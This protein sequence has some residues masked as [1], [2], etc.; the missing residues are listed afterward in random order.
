MTL[1]RSRHA[2]TL[3]ELLVVIAIIG[4]LIGLLLPA[5]QK[6]RE[7][8]MRMRCQNN[9][10]QIGLALQGYHDAYT[11][12]PA[13]SDNVTGAY[14]FGNWRYRILPYMEQENMYKTPIGGN[15]VWRTSNATNGYTGQSQLPDYLV[16]WGKF[17]VPIYRCPS[18]R[19]SAT[20][21]SV[22]CHATLGCIDSQAID[23]VGVMG[24]NPDP[25]GRDGAAVRF[26]GNPSVG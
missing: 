16:A 23:Y 25:A 20:V 19:L 13:G 22:Q 24:A 26:L 1:R 5:V 4:V 2:F 12:F 6:V 11:R 18:T 14:R 10:K 17:F 21:K 7:A 15:N 3:I 9:L 8:S